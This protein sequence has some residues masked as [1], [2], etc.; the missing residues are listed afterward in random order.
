MQRDDFLY[1]LTL[2]PLTDVAH[3]LGFIAESLS[4]EEIVALLEARE[5]RAFEEGHDAGIAEYEQE[6]S[7]APIRCLRAWLRAVLRNF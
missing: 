4:V 6:L 2:T 1:G 3:R 5:R 7:G